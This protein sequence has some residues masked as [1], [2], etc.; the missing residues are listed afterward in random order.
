[1]SDKHPNNRKRKAE[2]PAPNRPEAQGPLIFAACGGVVGVRRDSDSGAFTASFANLRHGGAGQYTRAKRAQQRIH[3]ELTEVLAT[4]SLQY[5]PSQ[6]GTIV[7]LCS[8]LQRPSLVL[9]GP[10]LQ[11]RAAIP[12]VQAV[13][14][15]PSG[16]LPSKPAQTPPALSSPNPTAQAACQ[17]LPAVFVME[18][19]ASEE[20][21]LRDG[22]LV[23][24]RGLDVP[25]RLLPEGLRPEGEQRRHSQAG[26]DSLHTVVQGLRWRLDTGCQQV[27]DAE[28][29]FLQ[30]TRLIASSSR[31]LQQLCESSWPG[32][33]AASAS[34]QP[35]R[36]L[37]A[38]QSVQHSFGQ[39]RMHVRVCIGLDNHTHIYAIRSAQLLL[40]SSEFAL[41]GETAVAVDVAAGLAVLTATADIGSLPQRGGAQ[42][43]SRVDVSVAVPV[44]PL[45]PVPGDI[46]GLASGDFHIQQD[47]K[48]M[49][50]EAVVEA[51]HRHLGMETISQAG[52]V[53]HLGGPSGSIRLRQYGSQFVEAT[54]CAGSQGQLDMLAECLGPVLADSQ[55]GEVVVEPSPVSHA[56]IGAMERAIAA[57]SLELEAGIDWIEKELA[58][59]PG[60]GP[61]DAT[62]AAA[63][64]P[65]VKEELSDVYNQVLA[66]QSSTARSMV[67]CLQ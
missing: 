31:L 27:E 30:K 42:G 33:H 34:G 1:M 49:L 11:Q 51:L 41:S 18:P 36:P 20:R 19:H 45:H 61:G 13:T 17:L 62:A 8:N 29:L 46:P 64:E 32:S 25:L 67:A 37:L 23:V 6:R 55:A 16:L 15:D 65:G 24:A 28:R 10:T 43:G 38:V 4:H 3:Q 52:D 5:I 39:G 22:E 60:L 57:L 56:A 35:P 48:Q 47:E 12:D 53:A 21:H 54:V 50:L 7:A 40:T 26:P 44:S 63:L 9:D 59:L 58:Q 14:V 66:M 2:T